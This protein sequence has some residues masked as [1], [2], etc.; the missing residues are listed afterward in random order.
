MDDV[1]PLLQI[2]HIFLCG[3]KT[4]AQLLLF[5]DAPARFIERFINSFYRFYGSTII[6]RLCEKLPEECVHVENR[7]SNQTCA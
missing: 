7:C 1:N 6:A 2:T 3:S 5:G 4:L